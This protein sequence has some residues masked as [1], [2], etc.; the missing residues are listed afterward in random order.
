MMQIRCQRCGWMNT[1]G[2]ESVALALAEANRSQ[3][4]YHMLDCSRCRRAIKVQVADLRRHLP[5]NYVL[6]D[7][8]SAAPKQE[9]PA[10]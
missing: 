9:E 8:P 5:A 3:E 2:R 4:H 6:P 7:A 10:P 1:L